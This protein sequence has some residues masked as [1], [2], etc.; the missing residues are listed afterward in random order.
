M[1][2][3][4]QFH[5][6]GLLH[7]TLPNTHIHTHTLSF[8]P[9]GSKG[10]VS[11]K[12]NGCHFSES[13]AV[14]KGVNRFH[15]IEDN[16]YRWQANPTKKH[17]LFLSFLSLSFFLSLSHTHINSFVLYSVFHAGV[18]RCLKRLFYNRPRAAASAQKLSVRGAPPGGISSTEEGSS[19][20]FC[21]I[22]LSHNR[23]AVG[24][25]SARARD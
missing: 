13:G 19:E 3:H 5:S 9:R 14:G 23:R 17:K 10:D 4:C 2:F 12:M 20:V 7:T 25:A 24:F 18:W 21:Q 8:P 15:L 16:A 11:W 22:R 1:P 6:H